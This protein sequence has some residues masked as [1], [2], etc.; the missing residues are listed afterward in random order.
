M[1]KTWNVETSDREFMKVSRSL[2][3]QIERHQKEQG[4][5]AH[6]REDTHHDTL[7]RQRKA[8]RRLGWKA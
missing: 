3:R 6:M 1:S 8:L 2:A 7:S 4:K 5:V